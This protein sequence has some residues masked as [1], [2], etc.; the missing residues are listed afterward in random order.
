MPKII[1][2]TVWN[3]QELDASDW[4]EQR[5]AAV[6]EASFDAETYPADAVINT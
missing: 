4:P 1:F 3:Q 5:T 6:K 2:W